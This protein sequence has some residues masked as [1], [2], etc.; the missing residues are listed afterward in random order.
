MYSHSPHAQIGER[1]WSNRC[2]DTSAIDII[3]VGSLTNNAVTYVMDVDAEK[4]KAI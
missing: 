1:T 3:K 2:T 4:P